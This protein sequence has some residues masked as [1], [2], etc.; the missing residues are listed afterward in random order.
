MSAPK[1]PSDPNAPVVDT[2][3]MNE[4]EWEHGQRTPEVGTDTLNALRES[5]TRTPASGVPTGR[6]TANT[7]KR[8]AKSEK[9]AG[10]RK[11]SES[12][13]TKRART[14][15]PVKTHEATPPVASSDVP[16]ATVPNPDDVPTVPVPK[17]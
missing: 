1:P 14:K 4:N 6:A 2:D 17:V 5:A 7:V 3:A 15:T 13:R 16:A 11:S 10:K 12:G 9:G 8:G